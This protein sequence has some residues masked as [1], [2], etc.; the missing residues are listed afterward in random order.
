LSKCFQRT[1]DVEFIL[2]SHAGLTN[3]QQGI[4]ITSFKHAVRKH[5]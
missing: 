4:N 3:K 2:H 1:F 5:G